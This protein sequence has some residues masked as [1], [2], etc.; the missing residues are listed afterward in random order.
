[1]WY[2]YDEREDFFAIVEDVV[3]NNLLAIDLIRPQN[4]NYE[5][6]K[7]IAP[8]EYASEDD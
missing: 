4:P 8:M 1:M 6:L 7:V 3:R 2:I 5:A